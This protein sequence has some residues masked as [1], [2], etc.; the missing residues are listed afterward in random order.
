MPSAFEEIARGV[1]RK[2]DSGR[3]MIAVRNVIDADRFRCFCLV[4]VKRSFLRLQYYKTDLTLKDILEREEGERP[5]DELDSEFPGQRAEFQIVGTVDSKTE[6]TVKLPSIIT[7]EGMAGECQG[8]QEQ[9]IKILMTQISQQC[10]HSL[11]NRKLKAKLPSSFQSIQARKEDLYLVTKTLETTAE[12][13]L[14]NNRQ[15]KFFSQSWFEFERK[16]KREVTIPAKWVLGYQIMQ[17]VFDSENRMRICF[18]GKTKS[19]PEEKDGGSFDLG[20][21]LILEDVRSM[22]EKVQDMGRSLQDLTEEERKDVLS[23]LT[24]FLSEDGQLQDLEQSVS[25]V[26]SSGELQIEDPANPLISSLFNAAGILV[27]ARAEAI[28][29]LLDALIELSEE[30]QQL[31]VEALEKEMLPQLLD[32]VQTILKQNWD[33]QLGKSN[34]EDSD[35]EKQYISGLY[36]VLPILLQLAKGSTSAPS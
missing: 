23:C 2:L 11:N 1:I 19:F 29:N 17:L 27:E 35:L 6:F 24:K 16:H 36:V 18:S 12:E 26:L 25:E 15:Y 22:E 20:K 13:T 3:E 28:L 33:R 9:G 30:E 4:R 32:K 34:D 7:I 8:T 21:P 14:K 5:I 10:L 31:V